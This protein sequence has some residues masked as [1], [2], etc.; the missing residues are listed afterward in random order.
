MYRRQEFLLNCPSMFQRIRGVPRPKFWGG[1]K[2]QSQ[3]SLIFIC[4]LRKHILPEQGG[5]KYPKNFKLVEKY[6]IAPH[7]RKFYDVNA[8]IRRM[9]KN[10]DTS[11]SN[12]SQEIKN[13]YS[14]L[15]A[16]TG[17]VFCNFN[18]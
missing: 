7:A 17:I 6:R 11:A 5:I 10:H 1:P 16:R 3:K 18:F 12:H 9:G 4:L 2:F 14:L 13:E 15:K 8:E